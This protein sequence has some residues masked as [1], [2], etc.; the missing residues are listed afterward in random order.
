MKPGPF[1][2][3]D[4]LKHPP[5]PQPSYEFSTLALGGRPGAKI[6]SGHWRDRP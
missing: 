2:N 6:A 3:R 1:S 5:S 4:R